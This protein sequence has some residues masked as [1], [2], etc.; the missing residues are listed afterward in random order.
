MQTNAKKSF[1]HLQL[2]AVIQVIAKHKRN[3]L[4]NLESFAESLMTIPSE[5]LPKSSIQE[6]VSRLLLGLLNTSGCIGHIEHA[7]LV[8]GR[9][10]NEK[11]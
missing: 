11:E 2:I 9:C 6:N 3:E 4:N 1:D 5:D 10:A 7:I 8:A